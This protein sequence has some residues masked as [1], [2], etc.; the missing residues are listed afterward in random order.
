MTVLNVQYGTAR[1]AVVDGVALPIMQPIG[2]AQE[3]GITDSVANATASTVATEPAMVRLQ[4]KS[5]GCYVA[6]GASAVAS[7]NDTMWL[8]PNRTEYFP[9]AN[10]ERVSCIDESA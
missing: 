1:G 4:T 7:R 2:D 8:E 6:I 5:L 9:C 3:L 10:G